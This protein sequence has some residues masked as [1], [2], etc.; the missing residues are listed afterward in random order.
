MFPT[1]RHFLKSS[2]AIAGA[3]FYAHAQAPPN[4]IIILTD[5]QGYGDL[6]CHGNPALKTPTPTACTPRAC[7]SPISTSPPCARPP[8]AS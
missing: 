4:V 1:R 2:A 7:G 5:D 8:A 6:S 3:N